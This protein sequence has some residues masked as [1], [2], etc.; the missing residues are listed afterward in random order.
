MKIMIIGNG[1]FIDF[2]KDA[3]NYDFIIVADG[4]ANY[5]LAL[6]VIP[7]VVIGD[8]DSISPMAR[9]NLI[10][11]ELIQINDDGNN[12]IEKALKYVIKKYK[13][14]KISAIDLYCVDGND[15]PDHNLYNL[16]LLAKYDLPIRIIS[17][18]FVAEIINNEKVLR[19]MIGKTVSLLPLV[20]EADGLEMHGFKWNLKA[21]DSSTYSLSN[22]ITKNE[23]IINLKKGKIILFLINKV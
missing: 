8:F 20:G 23:A 14:E 11:T 19:G 9:K 16:N 2:K 7:D 4:G 22:V 6:D 3:K 1:Q 5:C 10:A 12:D 18:N 15:R 13:N 17:S 21:G